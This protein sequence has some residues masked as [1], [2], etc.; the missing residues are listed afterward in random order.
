V[1]ALPT[2][3]QGRPLL[4]GQELDKSVPSYPEVFRVAGGV[5][6]TVIV[7]AAGKGI[8]RGKDVTLLSS[9]GGSIVITKNRVKLLLRQ[10]NYDASALMLESCLCHSLR[11]SRNFLLADIRPVIL[12]NDDLTRLS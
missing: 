10:M 2:K 7:M 5:V 6:N 9:N 1:K 11:S 12:M 8:V 3:P 4:L